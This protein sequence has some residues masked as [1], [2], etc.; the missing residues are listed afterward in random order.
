MTL[1]TVNKGIVN[2]IETLVHSMQGQVSLSTSMTIATSK[3]ESQ[4]IFLIGKHW[5]V[6]LVEEEKRKGEVGKVG[7]SNCK[8]LS[9]CQNVKTTRRKCTWKIKLKVSK[10]KSCPLDTFYFAFYYE[11]A[12]ITDGTSEESMEVLRI[13]RSCILAAEMRFDEKLNSTF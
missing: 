4:R 10:R 12:A 6:K 8:V 1:Q 9:T 2:Y 3:Q 7:E 5:N 11:R 13:A